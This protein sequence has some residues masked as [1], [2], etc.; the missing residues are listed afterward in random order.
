MQSIGHRLVILLIV[1]KKKNARLQDFLCCCVVSYE[2]ISKQQ[3]YRI[4]YINSQQRPEQHLSLDIPH[5]E[6]AQSRMYHLTLPYS[7]VVV[8]TQSI[9]QKAS[10][11]EFCIDPEL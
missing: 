3:Y 4:T 7:Y 11:N 8:R 1:E 6:S 2:Q 9:S 10:E 5:F